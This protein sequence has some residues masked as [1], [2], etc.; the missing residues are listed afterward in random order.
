MSDVTIK[1]K[2]FG[3]FRKYGT[4]IDMVLGKG[5]SVIMVKDALC[6]ELHENKDS[7][8]YDSVLANDANILDETHVFETDC[9]L[10]ILP[11]VCGG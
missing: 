6:Q 10:S 8:I 9:Q 7:L 3:A 5:C 11:P 4:D 2:Y 1:I